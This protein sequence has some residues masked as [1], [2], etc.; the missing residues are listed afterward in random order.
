MTQTITFQNEDGQEF[1]GVEILGLTINQDFPE[2]EE[3]TYISV[4]QDEDENLYAFA[5]KDD[6]T[7]ELIQNEEILNAIEEMLEVLIAE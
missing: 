2:L 6:E 1:T 7:V 5:K 3:G 4:I